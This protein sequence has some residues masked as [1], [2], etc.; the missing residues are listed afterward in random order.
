MA[1]A[2]PGKAAPARAGR[3]IHPLVFFLAGFGLIVLAAALVHAL[4]GML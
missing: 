3:E 4:F 1:L 2:H